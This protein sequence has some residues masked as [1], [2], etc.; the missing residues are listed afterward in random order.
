[1]KAAMFLLV[2]M[3][4]VSGGVVAHGTTEGCSPARFLDASN[5]FIGRMSRAHADL[6]RYMWVADY[7]R[8]SRFIAIDQIESIR[9]MSIFGLNGVLIRMVQNAQVYQNV[10]QESSRESDIFAQSRAVFYFLE[11]QTAASVMHKVIC[12]H[13]PGVVAHSEAAHDPA[14][15]D[16]DEARRWQVLQALDR[17]SLG[18]LM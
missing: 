2:G 3:M 1:M 5:S 7:R 17:L 16:R 18:D 12:T 14:A 6:G 15:D 9:E 8:A 10:R 11:G 13:I 4:L